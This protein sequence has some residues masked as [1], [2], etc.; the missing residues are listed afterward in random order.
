ME[1]RDSWERD[2]TGLTVSGSN[3]LVPVS[4]VRFRSETEIISVIKSNEWH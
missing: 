1:L 2:A 4:R 3:S